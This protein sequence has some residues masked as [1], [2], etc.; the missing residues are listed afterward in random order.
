M[1][2]TPEIVRLPPPP[3]KKILVGVILYT[4]NSQQT[5]RNSETMS[6]SS[7]KFTHE[8]YTVG[9]ICA[10][11]RTELVAAEA[12]LDEE[13]PIL[14]AVHPQDP[15]VYTLGRIGDHNVVIACLPAETTGKVSAA[16]VARDMV[17]SFPAVRF[18]LMVGIGGGVPYYGS[19]LDDGDTYSSDSEEEPNSDVRDIRLGDVVISLHSKDTEAV[20]QYD[21]GKS[22]KGK[23]FVRI[24]GKL[25][26][27][28]PAV[29]NAV[30]RLQGQHVRKGTRI[31]QLLDMALEKYPRIAESFRYPRAAKDR[32]FKPRAVHNEGKRSCKHCCGPDNINLVRRPE[33]ATSAPR[34]HY[35]TIGSADQVIRDATIR[36][37]WAEKENIICFEMEAAGMYYIYDSELNC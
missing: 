31:P 27:P 4:H 6:E 37:N 1:D 23:G 2:L 10:L 17:R 34:I 20:V 18:G 36:D 11:P 8:D 7:S 25:N 26:K 5:H 16:S 14:P 13:H 24:G 21:F 3:Q 30:S 32:L 15:N 19:R 12:M 29:L 33:R 35:G 28:P 9:W 22:L